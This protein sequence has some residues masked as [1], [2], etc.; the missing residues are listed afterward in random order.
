M[1]LYTFSDI[2]RNSVCRVIGK[3]ITRDSPR[4]VF[5]QVF[6]YDIYLRNKTFHLY[7]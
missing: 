4:S 6:I 3:S 1:Y 5:E 7:T 2:I